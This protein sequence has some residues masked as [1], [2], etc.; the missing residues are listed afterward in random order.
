MVAC[1]SWRDQGGAIAAK[2]EDL[3]YVL[4]VMAGFDARD[5]TFLDRP[6]EGYRT[7]LARPVKGLRIGMPREYFSQDLAEDVAQAILEAAEAFP[8]LGVGAL[9]EGVPDARPSAPPDQ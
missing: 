9:Q 5:S 7:A 1:P 6:K 2:A 8:R 4:E 3:A